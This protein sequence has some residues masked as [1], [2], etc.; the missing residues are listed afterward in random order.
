MHKP[1]P[2]H[3]IE[4]WIAGEARQTWRQNED[5]T[6]PMLAL[7]TPLSSAK[8]IRPVVLRPHLS[9]GLPL[10]AHFLYHALWIDFKTSQLAYTEE[11]R[12]RG[13]RDLRGGPQAR[14]R[15]SEN[16]RR[17]PRPTGPGAPSRS[18]QQLDLEN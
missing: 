12:Q 5:A 14:W 11:S 9:V 2:E 6:R 4:R 18:V 1:G 16:R 3:P 7:A 8:A 13:W 15:C 10:S 17:A